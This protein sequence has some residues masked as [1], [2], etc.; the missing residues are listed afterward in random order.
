MEVGEV[1]SER[2][3]ERERERELVFMENVQHNEKKI[4]GYNRNN[5]IS[6]KKSR[7]FNTKKKGG[8]NDA[9]HLHTK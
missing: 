7:V 2:G 8:L 9:K 4:K 1:E 3:R 5:N 6:N